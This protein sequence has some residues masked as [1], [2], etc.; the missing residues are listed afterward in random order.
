LT[1]VTFVG[2]E[3]KVR[4]P[5]SKPCRNHFCLRKCSFRSSREILE[6]ERILEE[7]RAYPMRGHFKCITI[8][9]RELDKVVI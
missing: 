9:D 8:V 5:S 4:I 6:E 1:T 7:I 3:E 2:P